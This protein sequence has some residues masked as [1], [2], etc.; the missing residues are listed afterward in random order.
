MD[1]MLHNC[2]TIGQAYWVYHM[3]DRRERQ[4]GREPLRIGRVAEEF[5]FGLVACQRRRGAHAG[6]LR[7]CV[8]HRV[9]VPC[10]QLVFGMPH[11]GVRDFVAPTHSSDREIS[12]P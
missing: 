4:V 11:T 6:H 10:M 2:R 1:L 9:G 12:L 7:R 3:Q 8:L 5:S